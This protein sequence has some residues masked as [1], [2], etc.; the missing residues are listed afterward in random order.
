MAE[1]KGNQEKGERERCAETSGERESFGIFT[2]T[3]C[4]ITLL[5]ERAGSTLCVNKF[6]Q[7]AFD[8]KLL[9]NASEYIWRKDIL[10]LH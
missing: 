2:V 8:K 9:L 1:S 4:F 6:Y 7:I 5:I 10:F 3:I